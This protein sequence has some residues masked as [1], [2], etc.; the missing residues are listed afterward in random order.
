MYGR[1]EFFRSLTIVIAN[2]PLEFE[3]A[4]V[5]TGGERRR[6]ATAEKQVRAA[7]NNHPSVI[8][9]SGIENSVTIF[10]ST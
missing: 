1:C 3:S 8:G 2:R 7:V 5:H 10:L 6:A 4:F 9:L